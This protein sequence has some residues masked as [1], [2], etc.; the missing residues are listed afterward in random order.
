MV[1]QLYRYI[2]YSTYLFS[3]YPV[4]QFD[5]EKNQINSMNDTMN[6]KTVYEIEN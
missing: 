2:F 4:T 3:V 5:K 1:I 6:K